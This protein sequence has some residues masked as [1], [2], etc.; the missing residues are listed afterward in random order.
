MGLRY[1]HMYPYKR[2]AKGVLPQ[3]GEDDLKVSAEGEGE[4]DRDRQ[5]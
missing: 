1:N 3:K 4:R 2:E 5:K